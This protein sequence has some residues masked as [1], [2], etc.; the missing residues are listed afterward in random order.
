LNTVGYVDLAAKELEAAAALQA[1][2]PDAF[3][4]HDRFTLMFERASLHQF[5]DS[6]LLRPGQHRQAVVLFE[7]LLRSEW[8]KHDLSNRLS[9]EL[10]I[11]YSLGEI[12]EFD[13]AERHLAIVEELDDEGRNTRRRK[14]I[15][16]Q[17]AFGRGDLA[18]A[19]AL[20]DEIYA[21]AEEQDQQLDIA[22]L[23]ARIALRRGS[24]ADA[25]RWARLGIGHVEKM[26]AEQPIELRTWVLSTRREPYELRFVALALAGRTEDAVLALEAWQGRTVTDGLARG[27]G[28]PADLA[29]AARL[30]RQRLR[31]LPTVTPAP[32]AKPADRDAVLA[33]LRTIDVLA[34]VVA[35]GDVWR[36][37]AI[38]GILAIDNLGPY[39]AQDKLGRPAGLRVP[40]DGFTQAPTERT[41][42]TELDA[43]LVPD[44]LFRHTRA[45]LHVLLDGP[46]GALPIV[47]LR[48][49]DGPLVRYR[50]VLRISRLPEAA[51]VAAAAPDHATVLADAAGDL[52][53]ARRDVGAIA[54][55]MKLDASV[56]L[57]DGATREA[58]FAASRSDLVHLDVHG[59]VGV[60]GGV[61]KL[62]GGD[63]SA[64]EISARGLGPRLVVMSAC[65][66]ADSNE[67]ELAASLASAFLAAG[68]PQVVATLRRVED[69][70]ASE[71]STKFYSAG[72]AVDPIGALADVQAELFDTVNT[73]WPSF[74]VFGHQVC[75]NSH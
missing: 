18:R 6:E 37:T 43:L 40:L 15:G 10:N 72:G 33:T 57:G 1:A 28:R 56:S 8:T 30:T 39:A 74:A 4:P 32:L 38:G 61:L 70:A 21:T 9:C 44:G 35:N 54:K 65:S 25:E 64:L 31:W 36:L 24:F 68:S 16:A 5:V 75:S 55:A 14:Q 34:L 51:C 49:A 62:H 13:Q 41:R 58:L 47:A 7:R 26:R 67:P 50:P 12:G 3:A 59:E 53:A 19:A 48:R 17:I 73:A 63:V 42:A 46:L 27:S 45:P 20:N 52:S 60:G 71:V 29:A 23:Q 11:A 66:S 22:T 69:E 2:A